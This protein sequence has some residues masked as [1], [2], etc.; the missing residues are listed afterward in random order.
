MRELKNKSGSRANA[1]RLWRPQGR[2]ENSCKPRLIFML[3]AVRVAQCRVLAAIP[4][5]YPEIIF[6]PIPDIHNM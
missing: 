4:L 2:T 3:Y 1:R 5:Q 6:R